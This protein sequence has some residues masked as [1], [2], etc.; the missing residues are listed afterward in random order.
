M[1]TNILDFRSSVRSA[2]PS[3]MTESLVTTSG[4]TMDKM[5]TIPHKE[6]DRQESNPRP[7]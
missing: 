7:T 5:H 6:V 1:C 4:E 3:R 2:P